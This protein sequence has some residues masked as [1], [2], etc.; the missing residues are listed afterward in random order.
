MLPY[1]K[2]QEPHKPG[3]PFTDPLFPPNEKSLMGLDSNGNP[4]DPKA[5]QENKSSIDPD[6]IGFERASVLY[7]SQC[8]LFA[9]KILITESLSEEHT[10][11]EKG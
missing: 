3:T 4:I 2:N 5:Y 10:I 1:W 6:Y 7:G 11:K 8:K 9:D